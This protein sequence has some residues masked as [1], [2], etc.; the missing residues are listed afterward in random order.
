MKVVIDRRSNR[1]PE[2]EENGTL[3]YYNEVMRCL[4]YLIAVILTLA[5]G[6]LHA[7]EQYLNKIKP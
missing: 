6:K 4:L 7:D 3:V 5:V 1:N 2:L